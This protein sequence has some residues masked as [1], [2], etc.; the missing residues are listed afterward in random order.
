MHPPDWDRAIVRRDG[1]AAPAG[2]PIRWGGVV[3]TALNQAVAPDVFGVISYPTPPFVNAAAADGYAR[4]W[5][6]IGTL[7]MP[8]ATLY[9]AYSGPNTPL[10]GAYPFPAPNTINVVLEVIVGV[11]QLSFTQRILLMAAG[12]PTLGLCNQQAALNAGPYAETFFS[13]D[14]TVGNAFILRSFAAIGA[15][16]GNSIAIRGVYELGGA[17]AMSA[18]PS[19]L[20]VGVAPAAAG[21][22]I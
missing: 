8:L 4:G 18:Q 22:G 3:T 9:T 14:A 6:I 5:S 20:T 10:A 17:G 13:P 19:I 16:V 7:R 11:G 12:E 2:N 21:E 1:I 15:V